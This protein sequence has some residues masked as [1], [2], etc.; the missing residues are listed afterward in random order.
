VHPLH[1]TALTTAP[2]R[3]TSP[4]AGPPEANRRGLPCSLPP[5]A[6]EPS[7]RVRDHNNVF[8]LGDVSLS[9]PAPGSIQEPLPATAQVGLQLSS[10]P[11][12]RS[13]MRTSVVQQLTRIRPRFCAGEAL[14]SPLFRSTLCPA[15]LQLKL[16]GLGQF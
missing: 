4:A 10:Y 2:S 5:H 9:G 1:S 12:S 8:A 16:T 3:S 13:P 14:A 7:L 6:Q 11:T 15:A